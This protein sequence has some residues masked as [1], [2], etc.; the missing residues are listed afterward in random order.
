MTVFK[1]SN[2]ADA[3]LKEDR[4][5]SKTVYV[6]G[7]SPLMGSITVSG[8][9]NSALKCIIA[10]LF[11]NEDVVLSNV[12]RL[13]LI[14]EQLETIRSIGGIAEW[15]GAN[16]LVINGSQISTHEV[17]LQYGSKNKTTILLAGVLLYKFGKAIIP[18][19]KD[20]D[21]KG[22]S[23]NRYIYTWENLGIKVF[24]ND[25]SLVLEA[26]NLQPSNIVFKTTTH[27][28]TDNAIMSSIFIE[29][30][31]TIHNAS[32]EIEI[33]DLTELLNIM[34]ASVERIDPRT[35]SVKGTNIFKPARFNIQPDKNESALFSAA[36]VLTNGNI[37]VRGLK[38]EPLIPLVN[39]LNKINARFEF[40]GDELKV[41]RH[42]N[43][44]NPTTVVIS[45][46]PGF[47]SAWQPFATLMLTQAEGESLIHDT[48]Y[49]NKFSYVSDLNMMSAH[50]DLVCPSS[51]GLIPVI[52][53][54]SYNFETLG[55]PK[56]VAKIVGSTVLKSARL[57]LGNHESDVVLLLAALCAEGKS[58]IIGVE[59]IEYHYEDLLGRLKSL[60]AKIW[61]Q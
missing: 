33:N 42:E 56:T 4:I 19:F 59:N 30:E 21:G 6:E 9:K 51:V 57:I 50:I 25:D 37:L 12:P 29:G 41:W 16:R 28:G 7:G 27:M 17:P 60:G 54:D 23:I 38:K 8:S 20:T 14:E 10:S 49:I 43:V 11:S 13:G 44:L 61:E 22:I 40:N 26:V 18:K 39:F 15:T 1:K 31:T 2:S 48:V 3:V 55:E 35:I 53:D 46:T 24:E 47:V 36:A 45:P 52:S 5:P 32:E 58:E 34:G